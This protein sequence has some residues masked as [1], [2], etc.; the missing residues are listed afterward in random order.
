VGG[1]ATIYALGPTFAAQ[2]TILGLEVTNA[3]PFNDGVVFMD[4]GL[5]LV[6]DGMKFD[7][8]GPAPSMGQ[9]VVIRNSYFGTNNEIDKVISYLEYDNDTGQTLFVQS[10]A[11]TTLVIKNSTFSVLMGT[12][13]NTSIEGSTIGYV[14]AGPLFFGVGQ[15]LSISNSII[16]TADEADLEIDT[17]EL[18]FNNGTFSVATTSPNVHDVYRW[19]VPGHEY[20]FA[21]YDGT[22]HPFDDTGHIT[23]FKVLDVRQDA[24]YTYVDTD[25]GATLPTPTFLAGR[26]ANQYVAYPVMTVAQ[27]NSGPFVSLIHP[28][29]FP[30][31]VSFAAPTGVLELFNSSS[32]AGTVAGMG[33][34]DTIDLVDIDPTKVQTPSYS[35]DVSG[36]TL[37]VTDGSHT[38]NI[39]LLGNYLAST[40]VTSSDGHGGTSVINQPTTM[41]DQSVLVSPHHA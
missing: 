14:R 32:F 15:S 37:A 30:G 16:T 6:L 24:T 21:Y 25:L 2:Q 12:A 22:I 35:G 13:Q 9:S 27:T 40:F 5:S 33:G 17:S 23:T 10:A 34:Q 1:P 28:P 36:G 18:S 19:A 20:F 8:L 39:A 11:P 3:G 26:S 29:D 38:A 7:G 4:A 31:E 41:T